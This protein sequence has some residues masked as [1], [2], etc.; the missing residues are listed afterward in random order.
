M[1]EKSNLPYILQSNIYKMKSTLPYILICSMTSTSHLL[2]C[3]EHQSFIQFLQKYKVQ[4]SSP[5]LSK[6]IK[7]ELQNKL[8]L[9]RL[10]RLKE[11]LTNEGERSPIYTKRWEP[12][13]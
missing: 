7:E 3:W 11:R 1:N 2:P 5:K 12:S 10:K 8:K 9:N 13:H 6:A 4:Q